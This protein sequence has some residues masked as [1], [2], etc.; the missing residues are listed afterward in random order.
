MQT[1]KRLGKY[2]PSDQDYTRIAQGALIDNMQPFCTERVLLKSH[3]LPAGLVSD[4]R[5]GVVKN[6][7]DHRNLMTLHIKSAGRSMPKKGS[8]MLNGMLTRL[9]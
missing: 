1:A 9:E 8:S 6:R 7:A 5:R 3:H 2:C 4:T